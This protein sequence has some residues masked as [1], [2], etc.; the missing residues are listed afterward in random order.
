MWVN[1]WTKDDPGTAG[2]HQMALRYPAEAPS[3]LRVQDVET[4]G[5]SASPTNPAGAH[6]AIDYMSSRVFAT[7]LHA[8]LLMAQNPNT[9]PP[10]R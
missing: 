4:W 8:A 6:N 2:H 9:A 10:T 1:V 3:D 7:A 5:R